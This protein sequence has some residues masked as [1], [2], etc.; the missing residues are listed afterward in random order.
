MKLKNYI[1]LCSLADIP[2]DSAYTKESRKSYKYATKHILANYRLLHRRFELQPQIIEHIK[3]NPPESTLN[4]GNQDLY[5]ALWKLACDDIPKMQI[6]GIKM[7]EEVRVAAASLKSIPDKGLELYKII[8]YYYLKEGYDLKTDEVIGLCAL[9][10]SSFFKLKSKAI[11][12]MMYI[13]WGY[14]NE[15]NMKLDMLK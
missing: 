9:S 1:M 8:D 14:T 3:D 2:Y 7:L 10:A 15:E 6:S 13:L 12:E 4:I 11:D 5:D